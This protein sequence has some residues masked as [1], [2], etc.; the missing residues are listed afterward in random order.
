[1]NSKKNLTYAGK[2]YLGEKFDH[3]IYSL[4]FSIPDN[5]KQANNYAIFYNTEENIRLTYKLDENDCMPITANITQHPIVYN[6]F[7]MCKSEND[8]VICVSEDIQGTVKDNILTSTD[9]DIEDDTDPLIIILNSDLY[10][11]NQSLDTINTNVLSIKEDL[12]ADIIN[13]NTEIK[14]TVEQILTKL[15]ELSSTIVNELKTKIDEIKEAVDL[16]DEE[17]I[18][19]VD[20]LNERI[21]D[22]NILIVE[23][24][25]KQTAEDEVLE[26][27]NYT[28]TDVLYK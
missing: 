24:K 14:S 17:I 15:N 10:T 21:Q 19:K 8:E 20:I 11:I 5:F 7:L 28:L 18:E 1:M 12:A 23:M 13:S 26:E 9:E 6:I 2:L 22:N 27:I 25:N 16:G 4:K 3:N